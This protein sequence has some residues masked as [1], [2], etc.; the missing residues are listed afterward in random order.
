[1]L[2][3]F[4]VLVGFLGASITLG[5]CTDGS[6]QSLPARLAPQY[7]FRMPSGPGVPLDPTKPTEP[8]IPNCDIVLKHVVII[9]RACVAGPGNPYAP[10][11]PSNKAPG[12]G[13]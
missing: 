7:H 11:L 3:K 8:P 1:M 13:S 5:G 2:L 10:N 6:N 12:Y 4:G 9:R